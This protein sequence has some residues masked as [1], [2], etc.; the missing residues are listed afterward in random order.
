MFQ[1]CTK[2][3]S[4]QKPAPSPPPECMGGGLTGRI[5]GSISPPLPAADRTEVPSSAR[6]VH[7]MSTA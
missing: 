5:T 4:Y 2:A 6:G 3:G 1:N 7:A